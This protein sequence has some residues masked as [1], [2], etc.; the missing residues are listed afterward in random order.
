MSSA[1]DKR[2]SKDTLAEVENIKRITDAIESC[3]SRLNLNK[4]NSN[5]YDKHDLVQEVWVRLL[6]DGGDVLNKYD[7]NRGASLEYYVTM[8]ARR[9][10]YNLLRKENTSRRG[11]QQRVE[12]PENNMDILVGTSPEPILEARDLMTKLNMWLRKK[13]LSGKAIDLCVSTIIIEEPNKIAARLGI[14]TQR[15]YNWQHKIRVLS[16]YFKTRAE[17]TIDEAALPPSMYST[18]DSS[19][20]SA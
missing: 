15:V 11:G 2:N 18:R 6:S 5:L 8:I 9:E 12:P 20:P 1:D 17:N 4:N 14:T 7:S 3:I 16:R 13:R 19:P 10:A